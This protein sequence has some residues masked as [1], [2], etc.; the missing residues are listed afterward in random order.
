MCSSTPVRVLA[1]V[2]LASCMHARAD[3][4][5]GPCHP[6]RQGRRSASVADAAHFNSSDVSIEQVTRDAGP[7][8]V[9]DASTDTRTS[10]RNLSVSLTLTVAKNGVD[11]ALELWRDPR[12]DDGT[13]NRLWFQNAFFGDA[14]V[15][16]DPLPALLVL[17]DRFHIIELHELA[18]PLARLSSIVLGDDPNPYFR[19]ERDTFSG[20]GRWGGTEARFARVKSAYVEW[21][22]CGAPSCLLGCESAYDRRPSGGFDVL[23][24]EERW[25]G[26]GLGRTMTTYT[27]YEVVEGKCIDHVRSVPGWLDPFPMPP[28]R[29]FPPRSH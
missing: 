28:P 19:I 9:A 22:P 11:G 24:V 18:V 4:A 13:V 16:N 12:L 8:P 20:A 15:F 1:G 3:R 14:P 10:G 23:V 17:R 25:A 29:A 6:L 21:L 27:R 5:R 26:T 7:V 2:V